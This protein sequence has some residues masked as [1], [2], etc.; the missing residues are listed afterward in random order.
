[1]LKSS[2]AISHVNGELKTKVLEISSVSIIRAGVDVV[3]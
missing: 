2:S 3:D 1:V